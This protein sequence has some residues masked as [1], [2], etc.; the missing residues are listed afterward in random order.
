MLSGKLV[1]PLSQNATSRCLF[2]RGFMAGLQRKLS[3]MTKQRCKR[4]GAIQVAV[5]LINRNDA[6]GGMGGGELVS[7]IQVNLS[8]VEGRR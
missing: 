4:K 7:L 3:E 5:S 1:P 8:L 6:A 2:E